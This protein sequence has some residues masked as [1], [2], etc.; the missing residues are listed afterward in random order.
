MR[1]SIQIIGY[2]AIAAS[3]GFAVHQARAFPAFALKTKAACASCHTS[4]AGG[5]ALSDAGKAF[6]ADASKAPAA[7]KG[8]EYAG[9][10]KCRMC[11]LKQHKSWWESQHAKAM[12]ALQDAKAAAAFAEK[13]K[14]ELEEPADQSDACVR[15]H[16]TGF[17]LAGGYPAADSAKTAAV[18]MVGCEACHG[19]GSAHIAAKTSAERKATING[20]VGVALCQQCHT[21]EISPKFEFAAMKKRVHPV[22]AAAPSK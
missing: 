21:P 14:I 2:V 18:A 1:R 16:V 10:N 8:A 11:H 12:A 4:P 5:P 19:P 17:H 15:C 3:V 20:A 9:N 6:K 7:G 13:L 22:P